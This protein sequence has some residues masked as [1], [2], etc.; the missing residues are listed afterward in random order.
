MRVSPLDLADRQELVFLAELV[1]DLRAAV[2]HAAVLLVGAVARDLLLCFAHGIRA[3]R[4]TEDVDLALAVADWR[5]FEGLLESLLASGSFQPHANVIHRLLHRGRMEVDLIPFGGV[6]R[7]DGTIAWPPNGDA[8][9]GVLGFQEA[10]ASSISALLPLGQRVAVVSL[11]MLAVLKVLAWSERR[12]RA[13]RRDASDLMLILHSY[14]DAGHA[15]R[16]YGEA[17]HLLAAGDFDYERAGSWLAGGDAAELL[18]RHGASSDRIMEKV[19]AIVLPEID[20]EGPLRL[21]GE[22]RGTDLERARQL[23]LAFLAGFSGEQYPVA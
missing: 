5:D 8:V 1:A 13:P 6:E 7:A 20:P 10:L 17:N 19:R 3:A 22:L 18:Q 2:P 21:I 23:L 4:A 9:M 11:P 16:L 12:T 14:L 15:E